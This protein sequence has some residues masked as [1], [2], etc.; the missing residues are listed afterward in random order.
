MPEMI[1]VIIPILKRPLKFGNG[2]SLATHF[3]RGNPWQKTQENAL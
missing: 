3:Y 1:E 2:L